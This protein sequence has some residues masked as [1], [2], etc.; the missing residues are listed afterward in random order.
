ME[1]VGEVAL[2]YD[3]Y[4]GLLTPKQRQVLDLYYQMDL[5]LGEIAENAGVSRQ[6]VHDVIRRAMQALRRYEDLLGLVR[7]YRE[8]RRQLEALS[9]ELE[10]LRRELVEALDGHGADFAAPALDR[11]R[12]A[13]R[14]VYRLLEE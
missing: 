9:A 10:G 13:E 2:L 4:G 7:R 3:F 14:I 8:E 5:S 6:A 1:E 11:V 12:R